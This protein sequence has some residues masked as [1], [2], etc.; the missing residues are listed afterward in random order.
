[1]G[2]SSTAVI[3]DT[4]CDSQR[5]SANHIQ[6]IP[7]FFNRWRDPLCDFGGV[8]LEH[9]VPIL[10][11]GPIVEDLFA[12]AGTPPSREPA[13]IERLHSDSLIAVV[14]AHVRDS[15]IF[16][17]DL[18]NEPLMAPYV[19][20]SS[21]SIRRAVLPW[22]AS[23]YQTGKNPGA[24]QPLTVGNYPGKSTW[25]TPLCQSRRLASSGPRGAES[26]GPRRHHQHTMVKK[27]RERK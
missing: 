24:T 6:V 22:L 7:L 8:S 15:R 4:Y 3:L 21:S 5:F 9:I 19:E 16:A 25:S 14:G 10:T 1:M 26:Q 20:E 17:R 13:L 11:F 23:L 27:T 2:R 18:C 12:Y